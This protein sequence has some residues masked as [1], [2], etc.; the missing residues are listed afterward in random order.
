ME[1]ADFYPNPEDLIHS[2]V[3]VL[4]FLR[5]STYIREKQSLFAEAAKRYYDRYRKDRLGFEFSSHFSVRHTEMFGHTSVSS[6]RRR[7]VPN[8]HLVIATQIQLAASETYGNITYCLAV[9]KIKAADWMSWPN[10]PHPSILRKFHFDVTV[11]S[12]LGSSRRQ[13]HPTCHLQYCGKML[14]YMSQLGCRSSQL[15]QMHARLSEPRI[16]YWPMSLALLIDMALR[17]FPDQ[18]STKFREDSN[19][20]GLVRGQEELVLKPFY[21]KCVEIIANNDRNNKTLAES[22]YVK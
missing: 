14:P 13:A 9:C 2:E 6:A 8:V 16:F 3:E 20:R 21:Q 4:A 15:D 7:T 10:D 17:E 5:N 11:A 19:W 18:D 1:L 22:F 12:S